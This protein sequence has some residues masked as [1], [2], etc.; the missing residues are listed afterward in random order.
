MK[1]L[2]NQK[3]L[4]NLKN[5]KNQKNPKNLNNLPQ[6]LPLIHQTLLNLNYL[7]PNLTFLNYLIKLIE[8]LILIVP[9]KVNFFK[10]LCIKN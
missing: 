5:L 3:N 6:G 8:V 4:I 10:V 7:T 9:F 2:K 1:N